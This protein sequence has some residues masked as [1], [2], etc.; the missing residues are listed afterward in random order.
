MHAKL[1]CLLFGLALVGCATLPPQFQAVWTQPGS[2]PAELAA[3][4][5]FTISPAQA[6]NIVREAQ[7]LSLKH[8][9]SIYADSQNYYVH[10]TFLGDSPREAFRHGVRVDGKTGAILNR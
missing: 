8:H 6:H 5:G 2:P 4:A 9:W 10:D 7:I 3:P 1:F